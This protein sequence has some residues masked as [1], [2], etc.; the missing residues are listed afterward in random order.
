MKRFI[1]LSLF[2]LI[3]GC[4]PLKT[5]PHDEKHQMEL[6]LHE[7][8]TNLDDLRHDTHCFKTELQILDGRIRHFESSKHT[9]PDKFQT[10][11]DQVTGQ[12]QSLEKKWTFSEKKHETKESELII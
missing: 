3:A 2:S 12:I 1:F 10:K 5:S 6:T 8:Q 9:D 4:S 7:V 11:L